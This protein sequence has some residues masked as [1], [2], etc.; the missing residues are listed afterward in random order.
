MEGWSQMEQASFSNI[1]A[2]DKLGKGFTIKITCRKCK[3]SD[4]STYNQRNIHDYRTIYYPTKFVCNKCGYSEIIITNA[5][6][7]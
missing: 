7:K 2:K 3:K 1:K 6:N 5:E 4:I